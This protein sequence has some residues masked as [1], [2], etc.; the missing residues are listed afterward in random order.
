MKEAKIS[1]IKNQL[2]RYL[3]LVRNRGEVVRILDR[4]VPVAQIIPITAETRGRSSGTE[5]LI[6]LERK[7]LI[8]RGTG[9]VDREILETDPPGKP[10]GVLQ[11]LIEERS[12]R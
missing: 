1:E 4:D 2:S 9:V 10:C 5:V 6:V 11:A 8:R 12:L 3:D 7:G